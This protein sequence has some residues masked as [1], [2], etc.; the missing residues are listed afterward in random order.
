M[1]IPG[2]AAIQTRKTIAILD[3][4]SGNLHSVAKALEHVA[5]TD[6]RVLVSSDYDTIM[7]AERIVF[8]GQGAMGQCM[9]TLI[10]KGFPALLRECIR[11]KPFLGICLGLQTLMDFSE[12]DNGTEGLGIIPGKVLRF[13]AA[14][15][16]VN[17]D[18]CKIPHMGWNKVKQTTP[19]PLWK[20]I[21]ADER[22]YFVHS[23][24]VQ[25][26]HESDSTGITDYI[27][28][29]TSAAARDNLFAT[30][31]HPEKSQRAGLTL[32]RNFL[33]WLP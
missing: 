3:Y 4:G 20:N 29:F 25:P 16:D 14:V 13:P 27:V 19:H 9:Q 10:N 22:F 30:Q 8:P 12:E 17:G 7:S 18:P 11:S 31:F 23:Y 33:E 5:G 26:E 32:L 15:R 6:Y 21:R 1:T 24:Y 28:S 2:A